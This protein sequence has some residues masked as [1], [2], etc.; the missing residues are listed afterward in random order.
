MPP[1]DDSTHGW[2]KR[3]FVPTKFRGFLDLVRPFTLAAP[4][5]G[6]LS[7]AF[8]SLA[9][10]D[11]LQ[12][13]VA[14]GVFPFLHWNIQLMKLIWGVMTLVF[15]NAASNTLNQITDLDIDRIN[16]P[17]RPLVTGI[18][19]VKEARLIAV[20]LYL[21]CLW[22]AALVNRYFFIL[23]VLLILITIG[24]SAEPVRFKKRLFLA[25][26]SIALGRGMLGFVAAWCIFGHVLSPIPWVI[27]AIMFVYLIGAM[28]TKDFT[29]VKGDKEF[30]CRTLPVVFG[31]RNATY[32]SIPFF[33]LPFLGIPIG[34]YYGLFPEYALVLA[35]IYMAWGTAISVLMFRMT[36]AK[37]PNFENSPVWRQMYL[38]LMAV[39]IGFGAL[40]VVKN[41]VGG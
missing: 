11:M 14:D 32:L 8:I 10:Y 3:Q 33:I 23:I 35:F 15:L 22:R 25:N 31:T 41:F 27:G 7:S 6:G 30:G 21:I 19:T 29:D 24:Y 36:N 34:I 26:I 17:K 40:F 9:Y 1:K 39:Q 5:I 4:L 2:E 38:L 13:P 16:K 28:T 18:V 12:L 37:D 20:A